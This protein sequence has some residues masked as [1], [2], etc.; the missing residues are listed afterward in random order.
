MVHVPIEQAKLEKMKT[1]E[2]QGELRARGQTVSGTKPRLLKRL[3][4]AL[5]KMLPVKFSKRPNSKFGNTGMKAAKK[6]DKN[7]EKGLKFFS[8]DAYW[9]ELLPLEECVPEPD[10]PGWSKP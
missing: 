10:N 9:K 3:K 8:K 1:Q 7:E 2:I 6:E 5:Q 4:E